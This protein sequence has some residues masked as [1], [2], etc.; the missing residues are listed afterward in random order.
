MLVVLL[1]KATPIAPKMIIDF[2]LKP[3]GF[4]FIYTNILMYI[5]TYM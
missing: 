4:R 3:K 2:G 5:Y 1:L